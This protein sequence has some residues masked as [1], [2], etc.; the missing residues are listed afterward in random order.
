M[1]RRAARSPSREGADSAVTKASLRWELIWLRKQ[2]RLR[3]RLFPTT[4]FCNPVYSFEAVGSTTSE[5]VDDCT[6]LG[7]SRV[8]RRV[9]ASTVSGHIVS[10][11]GRAPHPSVLI[12]MVRAAAWMSIRRH[13]CVARYACV[14]LAYF[15]SP[16]CRGVSAI[17]VEYFEHAHP[18]MRAHPGC[19]TVSGR[20][21]IARRR[22]WLLL[23]HFP[24]INAWRWVPSG[25]MFWPIG[26]ASRRYTAPASVTCAARAAPASSGSRV[27]KYSSGILTRPRGRRA[28]RNTQD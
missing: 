5:R 13:A 19:A 11:A 21:G 20:W 27:S 15:A 3:A 24:D 23:A 7:R 8:T 6:P 18:L 28:R 1:T 4:G 2:C 22:A 10:A 17:F 26:L 25:V 16:A 12:L 14:N 9:F